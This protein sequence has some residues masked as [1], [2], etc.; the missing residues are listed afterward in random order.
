[1]LQ[2]D[3]NRTYKHLNEFL[4]GHYIKIQNVWYYATYL[5]NASQV[6]LLCIVHNNLSM[7]KT[8]H[9]ER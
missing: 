5:I 6:W 1:M 2:T 9:A 3:A 4:I 7:Y 8:V